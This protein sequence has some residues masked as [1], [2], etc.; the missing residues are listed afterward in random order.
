MKGFG[1]KMTLENIIENERK[2]G[3]ELYSSAPPSIRGSF[4]LSQV[5][6]Q[7]LPIDIGAMYT[8]VDEQIQRNPVKARSYA[9]TFG[10]TNISLALDG[11]E[12]FFELEELGAYTSSPRAEVRTQALRS[13]GEIVTAEEVDSPVTYILADSGIPQ[14]IEMS[15]I[16]ALHMVDTAIVT[17]MYVA[18]PLVQTMSL[19]AI[20]ELRQRYPNVFL[21]PYGNVR[22]LAHTPALLGSVVETSLIEASGLKT[23]PL[24]SQS[25]TD[26]IGDAFSVSTQRIPA[27][28]MGITTAKK[29]HIG[30]GFLLAKAIADSPSNTVIVELN[31]Q[32]PRVDQMVTQLAQNLGLSLDQ[33]IQALSVGAIG[34]DE[35]E[36]AYQQRGLANQ[37]QIET[38]YSLQ[39]CNQYFAELLRNMTP[40]EMKI[41]P[42]ANSDTEQAKTL[43]TIPG[44][45]RLFSGSGMSIISDAHGKAMVIE[46]GGK[47]TLQGVVAAYCGSFALT[48]VDSPSPLK[49]AE[50]SILRNNGVDIKREIG[51][52]V[53]IDFAVASGTKGGTLLL[54][55]VIADSEDPTLLPAAL[56]LIMD[57][58]FF[59]RGEGDSLLPNFSSN[60]FLKEKLA[61]TFA[62][63]GLSFVDIRRPIKFVDAKRELALD[64][65]GTAAGIT[66]SK[67]VSAQNLRQLLLTLPG[68]Q[69]QLSSGLLDSINALAPSDTIP[70]S[71]FTPSDQALI[72]QIKKGDFSTIVKNMRTD[73]DDDIATCI[74]GTSLQTTLESMGYAPEQFE[75][76][77][78]R[79]IESEGMYKIK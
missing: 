48:L 15:L 9:E 38:P 73:C 68:I 76:I 11:R 70:K 35:V 12:T 20:L 25:P 59:F 33:T 31:D 39:A 71:R 7:T 66:K 49:K 13:L 63:N 23:E 55:D 19:E 21:R 47:K 37:A 54:E 50:F 17:D 29:P 30:H 53:L 36:P 57:N 58:S 43:V 6:A 64:L 14:T 22:N 79:I 61:K 72:Q 27:S 44:F 3:A 45:A 62:S 67:K 40:P 56:R 34:I 74:K 16:Q 8:I 2:R 1:H 60:E 18:N 41:T 46:A 42:I 24:L 26:S 78:E 69:Q 75:L 65:L 51:T 32:G 52:G 4:V 77:I 5:E 28:F 10:M